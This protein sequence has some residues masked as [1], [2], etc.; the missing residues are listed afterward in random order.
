ME[1]FATIQAWISS[2]PKKDEME[3]VMNFINRR[4]LTGLR[5]ELYGIERAIKWFEKTQ[6]EF[7]KHGLKLSAENHEGYKRDIKRRQE[8]RNLLPPPRVVVKKQDKK[9]AQTSPESQEAATE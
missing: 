8:I 9:A 2:K 4:A 3:L 5:Q 7:E 1:K 6:K